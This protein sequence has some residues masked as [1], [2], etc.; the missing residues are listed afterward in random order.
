MDVGTGS[1]DTAWVK[2]VLVVEDRRQTR[3]FLVDVLASEG[4]EVAACADEAQALE[5]LGRD[6]FDLVVT[7]VVRS[8]ADAQRL[9]DEL[10]RAGPA[11]APVV[12]LSAFEH[13]RPEL[14]GTRACIGTPADVDQLL[15][16]LDRN[17][18]LEG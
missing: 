13:V 11:P 3:D 6:A 9:L 2:R 8:G 4:Y 10:R 18:S 1:S 14:R 7:S 17:A 16:A 15:D 12:A 5:R